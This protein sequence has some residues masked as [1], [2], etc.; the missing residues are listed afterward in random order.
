VSIESATGSGNSAEPRQKHFQSWERFPHMLL[1]TVVVSPRSGGARNE[2]VTGPPARRDKHLEVPGLHRRLSHSA[3]TDRTTG[4]PCGPAPCRR[5]HIEADPDPRFRAG[6]STPHALT[7]RA[8]TTAANGPP[9]R[10]SACPGRRRGTSGQR[11]R[12]GPGLVNHFEQPKRSTRR[13]QSGGARHRSGRLSTPGVPLGALSTEGTRSVPAGCRAERMN[14][15]P[16]I[17]ATIF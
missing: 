11:R 16:T 3:R 4:E 17:R 14:G 5:L 13:G 6:R 8:T 7:L 9:R 1:G 12:C 2:G 15:R 10:R